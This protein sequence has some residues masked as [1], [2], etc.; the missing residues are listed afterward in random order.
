MLYGIPLTLALVFTSTSR[1]TVALDSAVN[2]VTLNARIESIRD[3]RIGIQPL[4]YY[5][6]KPMTHWYPSNRGQLPSEATVISSTRMTLHGR[7]VTP[8]ALRTGQIAK[9]YGYKPPSSKV[10]AAFL[11]EVFR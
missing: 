7:F 2:L 5:D 11:I 10:V 4:S 8:A 6:L 3:G 9:I 1:H